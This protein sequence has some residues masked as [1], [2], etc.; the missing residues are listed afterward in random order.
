MTAKHYWLDLGSADFLILATDIDPAMIASARLGCYPAQKT[1]ESPNE[2]LSR[3]TRYDKESDRYLIDP[4]IK[5]MIRFEELNLLGNWPFNGF[6]DVIFCRNVVIYFDSKTRGRLWRR[7]AER[8]PP[9]G[10]LFIGHSER[11]DSE[12]EPYLEQTGVTE[13]RRTERPFT[14]F[15]D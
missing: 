9:G 10:L 14:R 2:I 11:V 5:S 13:Y 7:F 15:D 4:S 3:F 8:L 6:F 1:G 12:L